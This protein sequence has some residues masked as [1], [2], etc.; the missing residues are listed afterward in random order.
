MR[1]M[2]HLVDYFVNIIHGNFSALTFGKYQ[3]NET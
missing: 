3:A 2:R 1:F